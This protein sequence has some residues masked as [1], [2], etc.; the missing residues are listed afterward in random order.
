M[1]ASPRGFLDVMRIYECSQVVFSCLQRK[2][3][4]RL[5]LTCR[6]MDG[7][8]ASEAS[9]LF[10]RAYVWGYIRDLMVLEA[11]SLRPRLAR[12]VKELV[13]DCSATRARYAYSSDKKHLNRGMDAL[14]AKDYSKVAIEGVDFYILLQSL[15]QFPRLQ[16]VT[17]DALMFN[18][19]RNCHR[20]ASGARKS[21]N[22]CYHTI[23]KSPAMRM[24][25]QLKID[26]VKAI[27]LIEPPSPMRLEGNE[28][29]ELENWA[30][31]V[32][33]GSEYDVPVT[34]LKS[35]RD[36]ADRAFL[37]LSVAQKALQMQPLKCLD[38]RNMAFSDVEF[39]TVIV[40]WC[41]SR[42]IRTLRL[43]C[44]EITVSPGTDPNV[45]FTRYVGKDITLDLAKIQPSK[46][47]NEEMDVE[48]PQSIRFLD[49]SFSADSDSDDPS[50]FPATDEMLVEQAEI[51]CD[52][53][54]EYAELMGDIYWDGY[55]V[56]SE[57]EFGEPENTVP[58]I[59]EFPMGRLDGRGARMIPPAWGENLHLVFSGKSW[60]CDGGVL[61][62]LFD[63]VV[64]P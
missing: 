13:W 11:L 25:Q 14:F 40:P 49:M 27:E 26:P 8:V 19:T 38:I 48:Q 33:E 55:H 64:A 21:R 34:V 36:R 5:R 50:Y 60:G 1:D 46:T 32:V 20:R 29:M 2:H 47:T 17:V 54:H 51:K 6:A 52:E 63:N 12:C 16:Q 28:Q 18:W 42:N 57:S 23:L 9:E 43:F 7:L 61:V 4:K 37:L 15:T 59:Q 22:P 41:F 58:L 44:C 31:A 62:V 45:L 35:I 39:E 56:D 30:R 10:S 3:L 53:E 24:C